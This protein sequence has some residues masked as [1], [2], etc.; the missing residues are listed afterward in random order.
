MKKHYTLYLT[1]IFLVGLMT[2]CNN[3]DFD[4]NKWKNCK[5]NSKDGYSLRWDMS[6]DLMKNYDLIGKDTTEIFNL[7][8][9]EK[10]D[11]YNVKCIARYV[12]GGCRRGIDT[13]TLEL[14]FENGKVKNVFKHCN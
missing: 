1:L 7:L 9:T 3:V 10:L 8:G 11:C 14:T 6:E 4:S 13:G 2:S 12:L 5:F